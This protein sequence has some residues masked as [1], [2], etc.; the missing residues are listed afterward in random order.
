MAILIIFPTISLPSLWVLGKVLK[1]YEATAFLIAQTF[2][3]FLTLLLGWLIFKGV[4][5]LVPKL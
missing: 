2:N 3:I 4:L 1:S 5:F